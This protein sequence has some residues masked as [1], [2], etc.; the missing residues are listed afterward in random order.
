MDNRIIKLAA[1]GGGDS[2]ADSITGVFAQTQAV[3]PDRDL[4]KLPDEHSTAVLIFVTEESLIDP[5]VQ[6]FAQLAEP[7]GFPILP[8][9]RKHSGF[10]FRSLTGDFTYLGRLNAVGWDEGDSPGELV[11][12]AIRR[13]LGSSPSGATAG[14]SSPTGVATAAP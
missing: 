2:I 14:S 10:D 5:E 8:V 13:H 11:F 1:R 3:T 9:V 6:A 7:S 4:T 12:T